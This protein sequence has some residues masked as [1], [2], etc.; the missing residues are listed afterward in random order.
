MHNPRAQLRMAWLELWP[1]A[2]ATLALGGV[3]LLFSRI[4]A[5]LDSHPRVSPVSDVPMAL[6]AL[7]GGVLISA[8]SLE[9]GAFRLSRPMGR[10][11]G[12]A[13]PV[14]LLAVLVLAAGVAVD[15]FGAALGWSTPMPS[16]EGVVA[17]A[18][19]VL[20]GVMAGAVMP[21]RMPALGLSF[22]L[23]GL[24]IVLP[25]ITAHGLLEVDRPG[26]EVDFA[27]RLHVWLMAAMVPVMAAT[28]GWYWH[29]WA[30]LRTARAT[31]VTWSLFGA[32]LALI[33]VV[34]CVAAPAFV[35]P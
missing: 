15:L 21:E 14:A 30:P 1:A 3:W 12:L 9:T 5:L 2:A 23:L 33:T 19:A 16:V 32:G 6:A 27:G 31:L 25:L 28:V 13:W 22:V 10:L 18:L 20:C 17:T 34:A 7:W 4:P 35:R 8:G 24:A 29:R 26:P 11:G